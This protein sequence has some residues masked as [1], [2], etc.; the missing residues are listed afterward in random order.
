MRETMGLT[1]KGKIELYYPEDLRIEELEE[2]ESNK[3]RTKTLN[4]DTSKE[5]YDDEVDLDYVD[6]EK[7]PS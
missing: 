6:S 4:F 1:D 5:F 7:K 3:N 2:Q